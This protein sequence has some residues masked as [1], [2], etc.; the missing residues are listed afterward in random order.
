MEIH[1][2][3]IP[4]NKQRYDT[5]G[6]YWTDDKG[7]LQIRISSMKVIFMWLVLVHEMV[8]IAWVLFKKIPFSAI[9]KF[10][11]KFEKDREAGK[12][13]DNEEPGDA[14]DAP[15]RD[16]HC[17][18]TAAERMLCAM[19][20]VPWKEYDDTI[21]SLDYKKPWENKLPLVD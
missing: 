12:H 15:Y 5:C 6:D 1:V 13:G 20:G 4:H 16:G 18:A 10:D 17:M 8:E 9:D 3:G 21:F 19:C 7:V 14:V 11:I 2:L